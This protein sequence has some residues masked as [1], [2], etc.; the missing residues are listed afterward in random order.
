M[1]IARFEEGR[2]YL[3]DVQ[4]I[5][6]AVSGAEVRMIVAYRIGIRAFL[7]AASQRQWRTI[8]NVWLL[9]ISLLIRRRLL[10]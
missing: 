1:P 3:F 6:S 9:K 2:C 10:S 8:G 4:K 5:V 7:L